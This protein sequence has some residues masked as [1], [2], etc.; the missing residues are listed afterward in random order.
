MKKLVSLLLLVTLCLTAF[1][2][3]SD[4][5]QPT[6]VGY[7]WMNESGTSAIQFFS[8][9]TVIEKN[10]ERSDY[11]YGDAWY[12]SE[13]TT[14]HVEKTGALVIG[15]SVYTFE[16]VGANKLKLYGNGREMIYKR[17]KYN[18]SDLTGD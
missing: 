4:D 11:T 3:C 15:G 18:L 2:S 8:N 6:L 5:D 16:F 7:C 9:G 10:R 1:C 13:E 14:W 12:E 17:T